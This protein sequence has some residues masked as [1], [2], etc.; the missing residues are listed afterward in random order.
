[1]PTRLPFTVIAND[2][3]KALT[4]VLQLTLLLVQVDWEQK[5][6]TS[7]VE[8]HKSGK[9][10]QPRKHWYC[11]VCAESFKSVT[12]LLLHL[13]KHLRN[14]GWAC[15]VCLKKYI[16]GID[17]K[18]IIPGSDIADSEGN[19]RAGKKIRM[20]PI[21]Q[22]WDLLCRHWNSQHAVEKLGKDGEVVGN[23]EDRGWNTMEE[24]RN[25]SDECSSAKNK[26]NRKI[27]DKMSKGIALPGK[28]K[29]KNFETKEFDYNLL[30]EISMFLNNNSEGLEHD[31]FE[32]DEIVGVKPKNCKNPSK[33][34]H[35][36]VKWN[37]TDKSKKQVTDWQNVKEWRK[38]GKKT[39]LTWSHFMTSGAA[40]PISTYWANRGIEF[41][42]F[43][44]HYTL[45][46]WFTDGKTKK[47]VL[48]ELK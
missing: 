48:E 18:A 27:F 2:G 47:P 39:I 13:A 23:D 34:T 4:K 38:V 35:Y 12:L 33:V 16:N 5:T 11:G 29:R 40:F 42:H 46:K 15:H 36:R 21:R 14:R 28:I 8:T 10:G 44:L 26:E 1:M 25:G 24:M 7:A 43:S 41:D 9:S 45:E 3:R 30:Q 20:N 32:I 22:N 37:W 19:K 31:T 6:V 17:L